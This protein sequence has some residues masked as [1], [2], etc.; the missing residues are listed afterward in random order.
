MWPVLCVFFLDAKFLLSTTYDFRFPV[1]LT[2]L[3]HAL[4]MDSYSHGEMGYAE[5]WDMVTG[6][7]GCIQGL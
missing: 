3:G 7:R 6:S 4:I 1:D 2:T 5:S